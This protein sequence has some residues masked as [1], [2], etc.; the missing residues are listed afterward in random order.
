MKM[1]GTFDDLPQK[2]RMQIHR[3]PCGCWLWTGRLNRNGYGRQ[4]W[5]GLEPVVHRL[6]YEMLV[7]DIPHLHLLDHLATKCSSRACCNPEH[8]EP[9]TPRVNVLRGR[10]RLFQPHQIGFIHSQ[11]R[12]GD[13][14]LHRQAAAL[15]DLAEIPF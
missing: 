12:A 9:V 14:P 15:A 7:G 1:H 8:L 5:R 13:L 2:L 11:G 10:A 6:V 3:H 4:R